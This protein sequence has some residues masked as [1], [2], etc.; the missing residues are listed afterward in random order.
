[1]LEFPGE[2]GKEPEYM[3]VSRALFEACPGRVSKRFSVAVKEKGY[4]HHFSENLL[5][6]VREAAARDLFPQSLFLE[7]V[8]GVDVYQ[9]Q[10]I[11]L[12]A[13]PQTVLESSNS[14]WKWQSTF[15]TIADGLSLSVFRSGRFKG[16][17]RERTVA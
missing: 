9:P 12:L 14:F 2:P 1:M 15:R 5:G 13:R 10:S 11:P 4:W 3:S 7:T 16:N 8:G 17:T 6:G